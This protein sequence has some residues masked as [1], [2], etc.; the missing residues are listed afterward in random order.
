MTGLEQI[1]WYTIPGFILMVP[2]VVYWP[3]ILYF[4]QGG[5]SFW[6][7]LLALTGGYCF[8]QTYRALWEGCRGGFWTRER[9]SLDQLIEKFNSS[10]KNGKLNISET[11]DRKKAFLA[12]EYVFYHKLRKEFV[13]HDRGAWHYTLSFRTVSCACW[14]SALSILPKIFG[15]LGSRAEIGCYFSLL[16]VSFIVLITTGVFLC[17]KARLTLK[18]IVEQEEVV[19]I[20]EWPQFYSTLLN[21]IEGRHVAQS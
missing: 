20:E 10:I 9:R 5:A 14:L 13:D 11:C 17:W 4:N 21:V 19:I 1:I 8:H 2:L 3:S 18:S 12:W 7:G 6:F 16:G 15:A